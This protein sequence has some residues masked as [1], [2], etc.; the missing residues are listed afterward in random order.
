MQ[1][2]TCSDNQA[3][4]GA[5]LRVIACLS[6]LT[7]V[8][9]ACGDDDHEF[10]TSVIESM[11]TEDPEMAASPTTASRP[12]VTLA[13]TTAAPMEAAQSI[14]QAT[15]RLLSRD[16][17]DIRTCFRLMARQME[18]HG[19]ASWVLE[20]MHDEDDGIGDHAPINW[21]TLNQ[22]AA[23]NEAV[24]R[25]LNERCSEHWDMSTISYLHQ[26]LLDR[27]VAYRAECLE[28]SWQPESC[29]EE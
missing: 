27:I 21:R 8:L 4:R 9:A 10:A 24:H 22:A 20:E 18:E 6:L 3:L 25:E 15:S 1:R 19:G 2:R 12:A 11:L 23:D 7:V 13:T 14:P 5:P 16:Y 17:Y 29:L 28:A 26:G